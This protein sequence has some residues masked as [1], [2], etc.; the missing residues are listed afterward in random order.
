MKGW[1]SYLAEGQRTDLRP[2]A[3]AARSVATL[4]AVIRNG[5]PRSP[6]N[7]RGEARRCVRASPLGPAR[8]GPSVSNWSAGDAIEIR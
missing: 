1:Q 4:P 3:A 7:G 5:S 2:S 8:A 6:L